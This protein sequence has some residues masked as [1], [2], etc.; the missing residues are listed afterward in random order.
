MKNNSWRNLRDDIVFRHKLLHTTTKKAL[1]RWNKNYMKKVWN[2]QYCNFISMKEWVYVT[3]RLII[4]INHMP[5][6]KKEKFSTDKL[7]FSYPSII[8]LYF[9]ILNQLKFQMKDI[10][11]KQRKFD[12]VVEKLNENK[13]RRVNIFRK[14]QLVFDMDQLKFNQVYRSNCKIIFCILLHLMTIFLLR[15]LHLFFILKS[16][17]SKGKRKIR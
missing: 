4:R 2:C 9:A 8:N 3:W 12:Q 16:Q 14:F 6:I 13:L 11:Q 15:K 5:W 17:A 1:K 10:D 7:Y